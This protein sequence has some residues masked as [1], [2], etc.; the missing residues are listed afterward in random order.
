MH[1]KVIILLCRPTRRNSKTTSTQR[2]YNI[3]ASPRHPRRTMK[4]QATETPRQRI[5]RAY[6]DDDVRVDEAG[7]AMH[8]IILS[9]YV[10]TAWKTCRT[11]CPRPD[12]M[13]SRTGSSPRCRPETALPAPTSRAD[14]S[15]LPTGMGW[16]RRTRQAPAVPT[17]RPATRNSL[18]PPYPLSNEA[19]H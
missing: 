7:Y 15:W 13:R 5:A 11:A 14:I 16:R 4:L 10:I 3:A 12:G 8:R 18:P 2:Q 19:R 6:G 1:R 17:S 9:G